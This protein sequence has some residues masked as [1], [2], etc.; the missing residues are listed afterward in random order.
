MARS[1]LVPV[2]DALALVVFAAIGALTHGASLGAFLRDTACLLLGWFA[3]G[4]VARR[5]L[6]QWAFG[7]ALALLLRAVIVGHAPPVAFVVTTY[8]FVL[9]FVYAVRF[10]A[11]AWSRSRISSA[12]AP[13]SSRRGS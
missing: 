9:L 8:G 3:V 1:R 12:S 5:L 10:S 2:V 7:V 4:L 13:T 11:T 6:L